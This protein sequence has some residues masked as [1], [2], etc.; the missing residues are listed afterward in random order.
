MTNKILVPIAEGFRDSLRLWAGIVVAPVVAIVS[1]VSA[2]VSHSNG[3]VSRINSSR[4]H[5][6]D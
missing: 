1:V 6:A 4:S 2:F 3:Y 5:G